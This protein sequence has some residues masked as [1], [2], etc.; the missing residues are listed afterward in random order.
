MSHISKLIISILKKYSLRQN[1]TRHR[2]RTVRLSLRYWNKKYHSYATW[3]S[4]LQVERSVFMLHRLHKRTWYDR[5]NY[6][7]SLI[8]FLIISTEWR[9]LRCKWLL[10][11][12]ENE[13][14]AMRKDNK[15]A[16]RQKMSV[17]VVF[18]VCK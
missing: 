12:E 5:K 7:K 16:G 9:Q 11:V 3:M 10:R 4:N 8:I 1:K 13:M 15:S 2:E 18:K 14:L 6:L 17:G